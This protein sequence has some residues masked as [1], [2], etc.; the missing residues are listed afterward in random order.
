[1]QQS[2]TAALFLK[3]FVG[4]LIVDGVDSKEENL[5]RWA[6]L[7]IAG[8]MDTGKNDAY[9]RAGMTGRPTRTLIE[10]LRRAGDKA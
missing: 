7:D 4:G 1:M 9:H 3:R 2:C 6:H 10:L 5:V 8:V